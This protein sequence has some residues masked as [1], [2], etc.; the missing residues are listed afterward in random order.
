MLD[1]DDAPGRVFWLAVFFGLPLVG[2]AVAVLLFALIR[3][4]YA[5]WLTGVAVGAIALAVLPALPR[6]RRRP[7]RSRVSWALLGGLVAGTAS[8]LWLGAVLFVALLS[9]C[10]PDGCP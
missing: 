7:T 2:F 5:F 4:I 10:L 9:E 1:D 6:L 8:V 3:P